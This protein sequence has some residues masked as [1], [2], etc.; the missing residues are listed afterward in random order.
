MPGFYQEGE[1]D[2]AGFSVGIADREKIITGNEIKAG[3]VIIGL[4]SSGLH[5]NGYSLVRKII[6]DEK[7]MCMGDFIGDLGETLGEALLRPT[8]IY[9]K[10]CKIAGETCNIKGIVHI[11][12]GGFYENI[13]RILPE[14]IGVEIDKSSWERHK[15]FNFLQKVGNI[16]E[17][18][19]FKTFNMGIGMMFFVDERDVEKLIKTLNQKVEKAYVIGKAIEAKT[20]EKVKLI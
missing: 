8:K 17:E 9:A 1:Y 15:I 18:E 5:S 11:T 14:N 20:D 13:P 16:A 7:K 6:L 10:H 3:D 4:P 19:M 2:I 12:G